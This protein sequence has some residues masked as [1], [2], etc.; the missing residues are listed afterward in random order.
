MGICDGNTGSDLKVEYSL[1]AALD[2]NDPGHTW[3]EVT[4]VAGRLV[5]SG[6]DRPMEQYRTFGATLVGVGHPGAMNIALDVVFQNDESSFLETLTDKYESEECFYLRWA[7]NAGASGALRRT[8]K[9]QV[10]SNPYTGGE[11]NNAAPVV[12]SLN[13]AT[14]QIHRDTVP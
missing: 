11:A 9:V 13:L 5:P 4:D 12:S 6:G 2:W 7:Y 3:T 14:D 1:D 8:A 10:L